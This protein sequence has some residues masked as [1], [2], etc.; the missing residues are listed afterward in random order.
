MHTVCIEIFYAYLDMPTRRVQKSMPLVCPCGPGGLWDAAVR[1]FPPREQVLPPN[2]WWRWTVLFRIPEEKPGI[3]IK[4]E[5][6]DLVA[7]SSRSGHEEAFHEA[8][9]VSLKH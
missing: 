6:W 3:Y 1:A 5:W 7:G 8:Q 2:E 9:G 4:L